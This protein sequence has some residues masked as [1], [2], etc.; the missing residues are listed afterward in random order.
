MNTAFYIICAIV[1]S[2]L[3]SKVCSSKLSKMGFTE[4]EIETM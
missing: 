3:L 2:A 4:E 1:I